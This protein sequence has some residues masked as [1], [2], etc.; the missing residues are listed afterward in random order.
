MSLELVQQNDAAQAW[1]ERRL[2]RTILK[3]YRTTV[4]IDSLLPNDKQPRVG[5]KKDEELQRQIEAND[6]I[7][8]PL[9]V[10]PHPD[11]PG[12]FRIIDGDRRWTNSRVLV[13]DYKKNQFREIPVE[14][15][16]R[17]LTD[18]E[19]LRV[20]IY[21]HRQRKEWE[22]KEKEMVAYRL[23]DIVGRAS[24]ANILGITV[25][26]LDKLVEIYELSEKLTNI[27][28]P[29]ASITWAREIKNLNKNLLTPTVLDSIIRRVNEKEIT[30]S[31]DIRRLRQILKDPIARDEFLSKKGSIDSS[32]RKL[33]PPPKKKSQGLL[34]EIE[35]LS[36]ALQRHPWTSIAKLKDDP[37]AIKKIEEAEKL[38]RDLK[39][40]LSK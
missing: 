3:T 15:T 30:N 40:T 27:A 9:L 28:E 36:Q 8:E 11:L 33:A 32:F 31:K 39:K 25:P 24:S 12:K 34:G 23:V 20:W 7:F 2:G 18:E 35:E 6:G 5:P 29:G 14:I 38:L 4:D 22:A 21:I 17:P 37:Q 26:Q 19:R 1:Q 10:E 16:N 13:D